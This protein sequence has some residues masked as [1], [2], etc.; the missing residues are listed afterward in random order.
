MR[1]ITIFYDK[2]FFLDFLKNIGRTTN[3]SPCLYYHYFLNFNYDDLIM[4]FKNLNYDFNYYYYITLLFIIYIIT[5][6]F[7]NCNYDYLIMFL[8]KS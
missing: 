1:P 6:T 7:L 5:I 2:P 3:Q 4:F 8:K